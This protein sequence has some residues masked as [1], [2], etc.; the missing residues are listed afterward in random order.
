VIPWEE[1]RIDEQGLVRVLRE[2]MRMNLFV[3]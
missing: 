2:M 1:K 3:E